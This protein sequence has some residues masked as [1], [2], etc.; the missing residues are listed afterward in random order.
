MARARQCRILAR[1]I[2]APAVVASHRD[3]P[4]SLIG[5]SPEPYAEIND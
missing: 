5:I 3:S 4:D 1:A 2:V